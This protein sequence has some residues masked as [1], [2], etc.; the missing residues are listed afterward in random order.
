[1]VADDQMGR[2]DAKDPHPHGQG[3]SDVLT[4]G[5]DDLALT[6]AGQGAGDVG[7]GSQHRAMPAGAAESRPIQ[8][9]D[10]VQLLEAQ[11]L[12]S[13]LQTI[14]DLGAKPGIGI[15]RHEHERGHRARPWCSRSPNA[16]WRWP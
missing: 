1:M 8:Q 5:E 15:R 6:D 2:L 7:D 4:V 12:W 10:S 9:L 3:D 16:R 11:P 14:D 13:G